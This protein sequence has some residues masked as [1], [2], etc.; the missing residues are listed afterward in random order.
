[1]CRGAVNGPNLQIGAMPGI[2][3]LPALWIPQELAKKVRA[4]LSS[5]VAE[6]VASVLPGA[7]A[8]D[9]MVGSVPVADRMGSSF[10]GKSIATRREIAYTDA[11]AWPVMNSLREVSHYSPPKMWLWVS[12][13]FE[14]LPMAFG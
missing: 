3:G 14:M 2:A 4:E 12:Q 7:L 6:D 1:M 11:A 13:R 8:M 9:A 5:N 10:Q